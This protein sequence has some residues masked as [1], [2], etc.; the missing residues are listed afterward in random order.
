MDA[1]PAPDEPD[2]APE[3]A[4][5]CPPPDLD[6]GDLGPEDAEGQ[7]R[8]PIVLVHGMGGFQNLGLV[9]YY[10][11]IPA[12]LTRAGYAVFVPE[13]DPLNSTEVRAAQL[14]QQ[15]DR[16]MA[17]TCAEKLNFVGHSQG[18]IDIRYLT[19]AMGRAEGVASLTSI[20]GPHR[21]TPVADLLLGY[22]D[23]P[24]EGVLN[25]LVAGFTGIVY[26]RP[27]EYPDLAAALESCSSPAR[28]AYDAQWPDDPRVPIY[29][30]AGLSGLTTRG[31]VVCADADLPAPRRGDIL[32]PE[33]A[34]TFAFIRR[35]SGPNDGLVA[36]E[37]ARWGHFRGCLRADHLDQVG[38]LLGVVDSF[39]YRRFFVTHAAFLAEQ[40]H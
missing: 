23:G 21:G 27:E 37:S 20:A 16:Y 30:Y 33:L 29:S 9:D 17:C 8:Y 32:A 36:V 15:V 19:T 28:A 25:A 12:R 2:A 26:G 24:A 11:G 14:A 39:D 22:I 4:P 1:V 7:S 18:A 13:L 6:C 34:V 31:D 40:G 10:F 3:D 5:Q 35:V 38:Q